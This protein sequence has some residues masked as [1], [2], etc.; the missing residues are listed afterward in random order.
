MLDDNKTLITIGN[1]DNLQQANNYITT[2][3]MT[4][5]VFGGIDKTLYS[6]TPISTKNYPLLYQSKDME[7][8]IQFI[9]SNNKQ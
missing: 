2:L 8:Y 3:N 7:E 1:F 5:Y 4:E 9:N 6:V